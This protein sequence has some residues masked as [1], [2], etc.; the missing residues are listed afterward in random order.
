MTQQW[1]G[2]AVGCGASCKPVPG[3][4]DRGLEASQRDLRPVIGDDGGVVRSEDDDD[5]KGDVRKEI[6]EDV[7]KTGD[8]WAVM[9]RLRMR[10][11]RGRGSWDGHWHAF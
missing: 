3:I 2:L 10:F 11:C 9:P 7:L 5:N 4:H 1:S 6:H 8:S